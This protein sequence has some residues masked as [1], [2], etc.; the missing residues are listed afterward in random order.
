MIDLI[1]ASI[2]IY[3]FF[4]FL[5][6]DADIALD[7][8]KLFFL[9][10][11]LL[12]AKIRLNLN[13]FIYLF[14]LENFFFSYSRFLFDCLLHIPCGTRI[15]FWE[16]SNMTCKYGHGSLIIGYHWREADHSCDRDFVIV[17]V[18]LKIHSHCSIFL[19]K[20]LYSIYVGFILHSIN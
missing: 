3:F 5:W 1:D 11:C 13:G 19:I 17:V 9:L 15:T 6:F 16:K 18:L 14:V 7:F 4:L 12:I 10:F 20:L 2:N 8:S